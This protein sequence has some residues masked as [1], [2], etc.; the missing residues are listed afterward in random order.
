MKGK[1]KETEKLSQIRVQKVYNRGIINKDDYW[2]L[3]QVL[4]SIG[5]EAKYND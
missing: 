1:T 3:I 4:L 2:Q 5:D